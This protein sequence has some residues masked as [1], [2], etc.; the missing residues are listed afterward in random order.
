MNTF[1]IGRVQFKD[2][3]RLVFTGIGGLRQACGRTGRQGKA[4]GSVKM[5]RLRAAGCCWSACHLIAIT[6]E[7]MR[8]PICDVLLNKVHLQNLRQVTLYV[9]NQ[10]TYV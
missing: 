5:W 8:N 3:A 4:K 7:M 10:V 9:T 2:R 6:Y 1:Y